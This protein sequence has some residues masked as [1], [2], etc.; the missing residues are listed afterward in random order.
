MLAF[1]S[2]ANALKIKIDHFEFEPLRIDALGR[3]ICSAET[4]QLRWTMALFYGSRQEEALG[5]RWRDMGF[6][7]KTAQVTKQMQTIRGKREL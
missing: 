6:N 4:T 2:E 1:K 5:L 7:T 3:V